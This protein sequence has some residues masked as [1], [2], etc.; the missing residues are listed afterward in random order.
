[1]MLNSLGVVA[2]GV[3][4]VGLE[5]PLNGPKPASGETAECS[6]RPVLRRTANVR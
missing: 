2:P 6:A 3:L 5:P 4:L 1:M